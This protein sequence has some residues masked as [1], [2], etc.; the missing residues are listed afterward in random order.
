MSGFIVSTERVA[1]LERVAAAAELLKEA[2][3]PRVRPGHALP[4]NVYF[5]RWGRLVLALDEL[6]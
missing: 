6:P 5:E 3:C 2:R 1:A 4:L